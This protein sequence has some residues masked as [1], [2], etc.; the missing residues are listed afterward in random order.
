MN[1]QA[2]LAAG[3]FVNNVELVRK[4]IKWEGVNEAKEKVINDFDIFIKPEQS[5]AD[6]EFI[7]VS[8]KI[9]SAIMARRVS[10]L[11]TLGEHGEET[12]SYET[13]LQ[14]K[15]SLLMA[16]CLAINEVEKERAPVE[17]KEG[18]ETKN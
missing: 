7:H 3:A 18:E 5:A 8:N 16:M 13:A 4:N 6:F 11:V 2:L 17:P 15:P 10:R 14:F 9:D 12:I 1:L